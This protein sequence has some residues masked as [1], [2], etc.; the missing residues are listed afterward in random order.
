M[1]LIN[2]KNISKSFDNK[3]ILNDISL[4]IEEGTFISIMGPSGAGKTTFL[5]IISGLEKPDNG[6]V[7]LDGGNITELKEP[8]LTL[9][10][11]DKI[12]YIFQ[13]Y[14]LIEFLNV[15]DNILLPL[16]LSKKMI[17]ENLFKQVLTDIGISEYVE[18]SVN[19]LSGGQK[20][21]VAIARSMMS[22]AK[23]IFADEPTG[24]LDLNNRGIIMK[25]FADLVKK[26]KKTIV[27]ITHDPFVASYA[28]EVVFLLDGKIVK[29]IK[30]STS[31]EIA[32]IIDDL[33]KQCLKS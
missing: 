13:E 7:E 9:F 21:R 8:K 19:Q 22:D 4:E 16:N 32:E 5:N 18:K 33:E 1:K 31:I 12:S 29:S 3:N 30:K 25:L 24:A 6:F 10:R 20:Q 26:Y 17:D 2:I 15:R 14:N 23:I 28:D 27:L 11:R